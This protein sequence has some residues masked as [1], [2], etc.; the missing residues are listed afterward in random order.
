MYFLGARGDTAEVCARALAERCPG[1]IVAGARDGYFDV[2]DTAVADAVA[3]SGARI[4]LA[5]MGL[6]RQEK[7][8]ALHKKR[9]G[10][11]LAVGVGGAFDVFSGRL[12][13]APAF[14]QKIGMEWLYRLCQEPGRW[15]KDLRLMAFVLRVLA[16]RLGLFVWRGAPR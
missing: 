12:S 9:L 10:G 2:G 6:P 13:R 16:T 3:A 7:W 5:A 14:V 4:L 11:L 15:K 8:V 1:L